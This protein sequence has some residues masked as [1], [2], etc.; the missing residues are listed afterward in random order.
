MLARK[1]TK[2]VLVWKLVVLVML[3][4]TSA[5]VCAGTYIILNK[6]EDTDYQ[7]SVSIDPTWLVTLVHSKPRPT[8]FQY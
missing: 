6:A 4:V 7:D 5:M 2:N 1:E 8:P 3:L